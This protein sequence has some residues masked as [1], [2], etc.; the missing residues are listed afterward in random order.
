MHFLV[1]TN[2][3]RCT[4]A[5]NDDTR[6]VLCSCGIPPMN[7]YVIPECLRNFPHLSQ[8]P[9]CLVA[10]ALAMLLETG[11]DGEYSSNTQESQTNSWKES[12]KHRKKSWCH[13][14]PPQCDETS[15]EKRGNMYSSTELSSLPYRMYLRPSGRTF[16][17]TQP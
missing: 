1:V 13:H 14:S 9:D 8:F 11:K 12:H 6:I 2:W 16:G 3:F 4:E 7:S 10:V 5:V 15:S 17:A